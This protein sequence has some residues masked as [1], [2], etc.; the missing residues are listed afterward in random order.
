VLAKGASSGVNAETRELWEESL[1]IATSLSERRR[2]REKAE[3][4]LEKELR[5]EGSEEGSWRETT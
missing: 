4:A 5:T 1:E 3:K 2:W